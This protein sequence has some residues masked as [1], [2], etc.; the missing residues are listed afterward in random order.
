MRRSISARRSPARGWAWTA[1][2]LALCSGALQGSGNGESAGEAAPAATAGSFGPEAEA[3]APSEGGGWAYEP[4]E[5]MRWQNQTGDVELKFGGRIQLDMGFQSATR[6][7]DNAFGPFT[8]GVA[9]R[10][11]RLFAEGTLYKSIGFKAEYDFVVT[12]TARFQD[13]WMSLNDLVGDIDAKIGHFK[14]PVGLE[15]LT[16]ANYITFMERSLAATFYPVRNTGFQLA[17]TFGAN[18][19]NWALG[20][21]RDTNAFGDDSDG[22]DSQYNFTGRLTG[23]PLYREDGTQ[24]VHLGASFTYREADGEVNY[25]TKTENNFAP[26]VAEVT[27][28]GEEYWTGGVEAAW[29]WSAFSLQGEYYLSSVDVEV[30]ETPSFMGYY[31]MASYFLTG[32]SRP[33]RPQGGTFGRVV[34]KSNWGQ[35]GGGAWELALRYSGLDLNDEAFAGGELNDITVGANWYLNPNARIMFNYVF[36]DVADVVEEGTDVNGDIQAFLIRFQVDF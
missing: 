18:H 31:V 28:P 9:F 36:S 35:G 10:R 15:E 23:A 22:P 30:G 32:E 26:I 5:G 25:A 1:G 17:D 8:D 34:P 16:S 2:A 6:E 29:V 13:V 21:F 27:V 12:G 24:V 19:V 11:A 14:E 7:V 3:A 4:G 33:Y 20:V